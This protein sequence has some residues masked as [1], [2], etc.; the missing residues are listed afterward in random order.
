[1]NIVILGAS[2][3]GSTIAQQLVSEHN[4]ITVVD[5]DAS[6]LKNLQEHLDIRTVHGHAAY[7]EILEQAGG[8]KIDMLS[9]NSM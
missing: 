3:V 8:K 7:P 9:K 1:M 6:R 4:D 5:L 2:Q